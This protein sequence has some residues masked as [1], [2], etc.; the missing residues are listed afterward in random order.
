MVIVSRYVDWAIIEQGFA[1]DESLA[2]F[3]LVDAFL[4]QWADGRSPRTLASTGRQLRDF[5]RRYADVR[6]R[7]SEG[8]H[9]VTRARAPYSDAEIAAL[10]SWATQR[11]TAHSRYTATLVV[12]L[13]LGF[14]LTPDEMASVRRSDFVDHA[15]D[16]VTLDINGRTIWCDADCEMR[17]RSL[18]ADVTPSRLL[19]TQRTGRTLVSSVNSLK[20][21]S[22]SPAINHPNFR[23]LRTTWFARRAT[24]LQLLRPLMRAYGISHLNTLQTLLDYIPDAD[25]RLTRDLH[26]TIAPR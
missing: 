20:T 11:S 25:P 17:L 10:F 15:R 23:R 5:M 14:G 22:R 9:Y 12:T 21:A 19:L 8:E 4:S 13:G 2:D 24:H 7:L 16:G 6:E 18:L 26:R 1:L 3:G